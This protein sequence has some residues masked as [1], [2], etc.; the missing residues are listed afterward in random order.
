MPARWNIML[1]KIGLWLLDKFVR[2][3][4]EDHQRHHNADFE[5]CPL[6]PKRVLLLDRIGQWL[7]G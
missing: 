6:C 3:Y 5:V 4:F 2:P 1:T 7:V